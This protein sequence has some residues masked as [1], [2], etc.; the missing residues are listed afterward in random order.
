MKIDSGPLP[1]KKKIGISAKV[2]NFFSMAGQINTVIESKI[3][4]V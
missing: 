1:M 4:W 3:P 2:S